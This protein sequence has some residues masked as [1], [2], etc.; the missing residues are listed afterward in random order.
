MMRRVPEVLDC[1]FE[2]GSMPFAQVHYPFEN[3]TWFEDHYPGDFIVEYHGQTR[4]WFYYLH[5][6]AT[7][8]FDR[9]AF[10]T[11][12]AHGILLGDDGRKMSKKLNNYP[13]VY[14]MFDRY[15]ADAMR[16]F[17]VS[18]PVVSGGDMPVTEGGIREAARQVIKPMWNSWYFFSLYANAASYEARPRTDSTH[19]LDRYILGKTGQLIVEVGA[20]LDSLAIGAACQRIRQ[21]LDI[22]TN[23][24][25]RRS[26]S[27][28]WD[29]DS[30][31][32]DTLAAV[33]DALFRV[34]APLI[35]MISEKAWRGLT[36]GESVHLTDWPDPALF[37]ADSRLD[38]S[39]DRVRE[40]CS[41]A[42]SLR[43]NAD[44]RVRL[45]LASLQV[46]AVDANDLRPFAD[47]IASEVNVRQ[48]EFS[49][50]AAGY[51]EKVLTVRPRALGP[52]LGK[53]TQQVIAAVKRGDWQERDGQIVA[54][55]VVLYDGEYEM[56][57]VP[58]DTGQAALLRD[59]GVV[60]L[61][62]K[63]TPELEIE[64]VARDL[65][66]AIQVARREADLA[67]VDR[68]SVTVEGP[69]AI[70]E[71]LA[72]H[73]AFIA[74]EALADEVELGEVGTA[75]S[76]GEVGDGQTIRIAVRRVESPS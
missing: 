32:F 56:S 23:W 27:R 63:V 41:A 37:P 16:W 68:I 7:A 10:R 47:L 1:W 2:S 40:V 14:E 18:S 57:L 50:S 12:L 70:A 39:M 8:L 17:L 75:G 55:G 42:L 22:L 11:C 45:P 5:V 53:D 74:A 54:G 20:A 9:P 61:D 19:L 38:R 46:A 73:G 36:G 52:R 66:R 67:V 64:G 28:F 34:A 4:A 65:L 49:D 6:I 3:Q 30:D 25:I 44:I 31:A 33:L 59:G 24:Y 76:V 72:A 29:E 43:K 60:V 71:A 35:P 26:R 21:F 48:V 13:D 15:G 69:T 58:R 51:A 62:S